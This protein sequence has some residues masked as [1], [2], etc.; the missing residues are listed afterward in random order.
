MNYVHEI[1]RH[2]TCERCGFS[3]VRILECNYLQRIRA[4]GVFTVAYDNCMHP[5]VV[6]KNKYPVKC[7]ISKCPA[8]KERYSKI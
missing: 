5:S 3:P 4:V 1:D 8:I 6:N 7:D 2:Y